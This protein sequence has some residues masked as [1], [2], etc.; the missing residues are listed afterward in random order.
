MRRRLALLLILCGAAIAWAATRPE[1]TRD[2][3]L[4]TVAP[5]EAVAAEYPIPST[6]IAGMPNG[7]LI[8]LADNPLETLL[9]R[10]FQRSQIKRIRVQVPYDDVARGGY[11]RRYLDA[12]FD[13]ARANGIEPLVSFN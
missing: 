6:R 9:D 1:G 12:W 3:V 11:R 4:A 5:E 10:R 2:A 8:G 7:P 13:T